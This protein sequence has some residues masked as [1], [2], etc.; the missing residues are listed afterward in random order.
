M[1]QL[2]AMQGCVIMPETTLIILPDVVLMIINHNNYTRLRS[3]FE[4]HLASYTV[5]HCNAN[6]GIH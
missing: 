6:L 5:Y 4:P 3:H 2:V 1:V